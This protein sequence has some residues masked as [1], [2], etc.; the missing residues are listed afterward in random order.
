VTEV[1]ERGPQ[2]GDT[3]AL[4]SRLLVDDDVR[5]EGLVVAV[6]DDGLVSAEFPQPPHS[7]MTVT[8]KPEH[9]T[10]VHKAPTYEDLLAAISDEFWKLAPD[11]IVEAAHKDI[12]FPV[13]YQN[14]MGAV[15]DA[16]ARCWARHEAADTKGTPS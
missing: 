1:V 9:F 5:R 16:F 12:T 11:Y 6:A 10:V 3:V 8:S 14:L 2:V 4:V 15:E 13:C 7:P